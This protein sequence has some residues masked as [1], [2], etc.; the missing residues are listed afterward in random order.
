MLKVENLQYRHRGQRKEGRSGMEKNTFCLTGIHFTL[1]RGYIM[2]LLGL[3]GAGKSTLMNLLLG[4]M[5]PDKGRVTLDGE[6][7]YTIRQKALQRIAVVSDRAEFLKYR[8]L[9]DNAELFGMLYDNFD[10]ERWENYMNQFGFGEG[11]RRLCYD[12]LSTGL[13]RR[14]QLAFSLSYQPELLLLDEPTA[15]L[16]PHARVEWM[17]L[18]QKQAVQEECSVIMT[19]HLTDDLDRIA[20]YI[21]VLDRGRQLAFMDRE[22]MVDRYGEI[23]LDKLLVMMTEEPLTDW[24]EGGRQRWIR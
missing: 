15:N 16:D 6:D 7:I 19:T 11:Q 23:E 8:T 22:E 18:L 3:N 14:F 2:G 10:R 1:E 12:D 20:D 24:E 4:N 9:E 17:E 5:I 21:L 13:K